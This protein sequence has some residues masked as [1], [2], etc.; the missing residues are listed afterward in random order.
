MVI[1]SRITDS[2]LRRLGDMS[3][4]ISLE[5]VDESS[6]PTPF[7]LCLITWSELVSIRTVPA[8]R[9]QVQVLLWI[10]V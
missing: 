4:R 8:G 5:A 10:I 1:F 6:P 7:D 9:P 2:C 3:I